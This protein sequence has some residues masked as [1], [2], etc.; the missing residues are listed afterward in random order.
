M[1]TKAG[2]T[3]ELKP[4]EYYE[5]FDLSIDCNN[6]LCSFSGSVGIFV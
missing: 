1:I 2:S 5:S 4:N 6:G 3:R